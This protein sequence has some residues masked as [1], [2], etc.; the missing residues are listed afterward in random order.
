MVALICDA[1]AMQHLHTN[2]SAKC[3]GYKPHKYG[4]EAELDM[5][6][7][8]YLNRLLKWLIFRS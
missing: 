4:E 8:K 2:N 6:Y 1:V 7:R 3:A 5:G